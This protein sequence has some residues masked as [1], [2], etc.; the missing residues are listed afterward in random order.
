MAVVYVAV[1]SFFTTAPPSGTLLLASVNVTDP[2]GELPVTVA[3]SVTVSPITTEADAPPF[4]VNVVVDVV[5]AAN[6]GRT[7]TRRTNRNTPHRTAVLRA[8]TL[9]FFSDGGTEN[10]LTLRRGRF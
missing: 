8:I 3:T 2:V 5:F 1:P 10:P 9:T 4:T 7:E 6:T